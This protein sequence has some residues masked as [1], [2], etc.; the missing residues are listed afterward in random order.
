MCLA[1]PQFREE[2][3]LPGT[4]SEA[5]LPLKIGKKLLGVLDI[6]SDKI[7]GFHPNDLLVFRTL[8]DNIAMAV[9]KSQIFSE[10]VTRAEHLSIVAEVSKELTSIP[11]LTELLY[12]VASII[13]ERLK[14]PHVYVFTVHT[15]RRQIIFEAGSGEWAHSLAGYSISMDNPSGMIPWVIRNER[16]LLANNVQKEPYYSPSPFPP[17]NTKSELTIPLIFNK[18]PVGVLDIQSD[19]KNAF[20]P[21]DQEIC[22]ALADTIAVAIYKAEL[23]RTERWRRQVADSLRDVTGLISAEMGVDEVI[24]SVL[25]ELQQNLP[26]DIAAAWL[27]DGDDLYLAHIHGSDLVETEDARKSWPET[28]KV[29]G[30]ILLT[31]QPIIRKPTDPF[32]PTGIARG[33]SADYSSISVALRVGDRSLGLLTLSHHTTGR[34]GHEAEAVITTFANY[35][36]VA[37]ENARLYDSAQEQAYASAALLQVAQTITDSPNYPGNPKFHCTYF[38]HIGRSKGLCDLFMGRQPI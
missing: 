16:I 25:R 23:F 7:N 20:S 12:R 14:F 33:F 22:E 4:K 10:L 31:T 1:E 32:E 24:D 26:C 18:N 17:E 30:E 6:Q 35:S 15:N 2:R 9:N 21:E 29:L 38:T 19:R 36:A 27:L 28:E 13:H 34:Y 11:D 37:I 5:V 8:A 3:L